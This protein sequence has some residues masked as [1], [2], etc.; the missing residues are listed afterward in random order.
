METLAADARA[1][2]RPSPAR[3][4]LGG[5]ARRT[6]EAM[7]LC[8]AAGFDCIIIET[9]GVGQSETQA[10]L[11]SDVFLL[12]VSPV[13]GDELQG[14]KRG[15]M[16]RADLVIV[17]KC[18]GDLSK[19]A[20]ASAAEIANALRLFA[21]RSTAWQVPVMCVSSREKTGIDEVRKKLDEYR[22]LLE[23]NGALR[24]RRR[25]QAEEWLWVETREQLLAELKKKSR[26]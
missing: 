15:I 24:E 23:A 2:I 26:G 17:N 21:S 20:Q 11:M 14:I 12:L 1:F 9:V 4:T 3:E 10:A 19:Q 25:S 16:E 5:V 6:R 22:A 18:D 8:E 13:A 7:L